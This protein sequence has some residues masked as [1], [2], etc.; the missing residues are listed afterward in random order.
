MGEHKSGKGRRLSAREG[1]QYNQDG[2]IQ[3]E[4]F[5]E[6]VTLKQRLKG[7]EILYTPE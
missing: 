5:I 4:I 1:E 7:D 3:E 2:M 6:N